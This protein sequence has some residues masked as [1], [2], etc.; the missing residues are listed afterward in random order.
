MVDEAPHGE[1]LLAL[2]LMELE[3]EK[4]GAPPAGDLDDA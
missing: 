4:P 2:Q 1:V 3:S